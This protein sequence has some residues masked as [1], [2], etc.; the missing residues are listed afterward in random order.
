MIEF[1]ILNE[2]TFRTIEMWIGMN[3]ELIKSQKNMT[4]SFFRAFM[5]RDAFET[6]WK[7]TELIIDSQIDLMENA[8]RFIASLRWSFKPVES[9]KI[10]ITE[11]E[12]DKELKE[13]VRKE[14]RK[15]K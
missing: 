5:P 11:G 1:N 12:A 15:G 14:Q 10:E 2:I 7:P 6:F 9:K 13:E 3:R 4:K 8:E